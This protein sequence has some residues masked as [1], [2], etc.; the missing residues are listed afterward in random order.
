MREHA[1]AVFKLLRFL[2]TWPE[3]LSVASAL[4]RIEELQTLPRSTLVNQS[5]LEG[6]IPSLGLHPSQGLGTEEY[7]WPEFL[8]PCTGKGLQI[9][10]YPTQFSKYLAFL[11]GFEIKSYLEI[12]VAYGG[13]FR[14]YG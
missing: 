2:G 10:Q 13:D 5:F 14:A 11:S 1:P 6:F 8:S 7:E 3:L 12:G 4:K 9:W